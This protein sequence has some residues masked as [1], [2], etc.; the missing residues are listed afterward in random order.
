MNLRAL[1]RTLSVTAISAA[2]CLS[3][4]GSASAN[5]VSTQNGF[6]GATE[7][8]AWTRAVSGDA[9]AF[10][11]GTTDAH[12]GGVIGLLSAY[13]GTAS[14]SIRLPAYPDMTSCAAQVWVRHN[15][16]GRGTGTYR[17]EVFDDQAVYYDQVITPGTDW[18]VYPTMDMYPA[19][20]NHFTSALI[21][22]ISIDV[23][24]SPAASGVDIDD[25]AAVCQ[26]F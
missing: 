13:H 7:Q 10:T 22:R 19:S 24:D 11:F 23:P 16:L 2:L 20:G 26:G 12:G 17:I 3:L 14:W 1:A 9:Q 18:T 6:E 15:N 25:F 8:A 21:M 5:V 4:A